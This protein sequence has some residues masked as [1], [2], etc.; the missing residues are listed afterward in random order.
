MG[1]LEIFLFYAYTDSMKF[2]VLR[3]LVL[4]S[5][6]VF[7]LMTG[8]Q[9]PDYF[10]EYEGINLLGSSSLADWQLMPDYS[11]ETGTSAVDYMKYTPETGQAGPHAG[12]VYR[13]EIKNLINNGDFENGTSE[14]WFFSEAPF[15]S[16]TS[17]AT[18]SAQVSIISSGPSVLEDNTLYFENLNKNQQLG[19]ACPGPAGSSS[20]VKPETYIYGKNY[21]FSYD[22]RIERF[23]RALFRPHW[24]SS[25]SEKEYKAYGG[26]NG[27]IS[28]TGGMEKNHFPPLDIEI[29]EGTNANNFDAA[30]PGA[31]EENCWVI[32]LSDTQKGSLDNFK[33]VR[34]TLGNFDLRLRLKLYLKNNNG[35]DLIPGYYRFSIY[36]KEESSPADNSF[37]ADRI[38]LGIKSQDDPNKKNV[39]DY[40]VYYKTVTLHNLYAQDGRSHQGWDSSGWTRLTLASSQLLQIPGNSDEPVMELSISPSN[41]GSSDSG[42]NRLNPGV[43]LIADPQLEYSATPW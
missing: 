2:S 43:I 4:F 31:G 37:P 30:V 38:E 22:Y 17:P 26:E 11:F 18:G 9:E 39:E 8:C 20:F 27:T 29:A 42:W 23:Q 41:P 15:S 24:S 32:A 5:L 14:P 19:F 34:N 12:P 16:K 10:G 3:R 28:T 25:N 40:Q 7:L 21:I 33:V 36:V 6:S 13:L 35:L 1:K